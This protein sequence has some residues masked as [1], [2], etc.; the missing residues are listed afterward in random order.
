MD[1]E[2]YSKAEPVLLPLYPRLV[3]T[4]LLE[5][6][7]EKDKF[8][9][10]LDLTAEQLHD[11][12]YRLTIQQHE[13]FILCALH[14]AGDPHLAIQ[15]SRQQDPDTT[16]LALLAVANSGQISRAL[17][18]VQR[19]EVPVSQPAG[20]YDVSAQFPFEVAFGQAAAR[21]F[22]SKDLLD[23]PMKQA[24]PQTVRLLLEISE[25]PLD[26]AEMSLAGQ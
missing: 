20:F 6:E 19:V 2:L 10:G 17:Y 4:T 13:Q 7:Y 11:E 8:F 26:E 18:L 21:V 22:F 9:A 25:R 1:Q 23:Q 3:L 24:D 5:L 16:N 12:K 14:I 15:L